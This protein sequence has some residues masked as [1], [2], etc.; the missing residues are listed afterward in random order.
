[1]DERLRD[2]ERRAHHGDLET[3]A[4][5]AHARRRA[6]APAATR[7]LAFVGAPD[8]PPLRTADLPPGWAAAPTLNGTVD[9][10]EEVRR[11]VRSSFGW[12]VE[13]ACAGAPPDAA[14]G[15]LALLDE[16][17]VAPEHP[18]RFDL[19]SQLVLGLRRW[20][21]EAFVRGATAVLS[22]ACEAPDE[23]QRAAF[24][25][26]AGW[27]GASGDEAAPAALRACTA[28]RPDLAASGTADARWKHDHPVEAGLCHLARSLHLDHERLDAAHALTRLRHV[29]ARELERA[30]REAMWA[31]ATQPNARV[32]DDG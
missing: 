29:D 32:V 3:Q 30:L 4:R 9:L 2:L 7:L 10:A 1:M 11:A 31:W 23:R 19:L 15:L 17:G 21:H 20:G 14:R 18:A 8:A 16:L 5:L 27:V 12:D 6:L 24:D 28:L 25:A 13:L 22:R 26:L